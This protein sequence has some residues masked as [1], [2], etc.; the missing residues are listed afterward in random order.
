MHGFEYRWL[1]LNPLMR[2]LFL[3]IAVAAF[4]ASCLF[5][6]PAA[7]A[8]AAAPTATLAA[9]VPPEAEIDWPRTALRLWFLVPQ[10]VPLSPR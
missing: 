5:L 8:P 10:I 9:A 4:C 3:S 1:L 7:T 2:G 6:D